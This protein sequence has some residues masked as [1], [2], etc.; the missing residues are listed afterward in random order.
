MFKSHSVSFDKRRSNWSSI[1]ASEIS[2]E[3]RIHKLNL[4]LVEQLQTDIPLD[5]APSHSV[6]GKC[7]VAEDPV[8]GHFTSIAH[9]RPSP[10]GFLI[11]VAVASA[12]RIDY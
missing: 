4:R 11:A 2:H 9:R 3:F 12:E 5:F 10:R 8:L 7:H 1:S 6:I